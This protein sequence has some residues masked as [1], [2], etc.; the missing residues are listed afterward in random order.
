[1]TV[2]SFVLGTC[3]GSFVLC[4]TNRL[5]DGKPIGGRSHCDRCKH[6]LSWY[7]L[8][9]VVSWIAMRGRCRYCRGKIPVSFVG[10]EVLM[11]I[12]HAVIGYRYGVS[13]FTVLLWC[14]MAVVLS[15]SIEDINKYTIHDGYHVLLV[16]CRVVYAV[17]EKEKYFLLFV[18]EGLLVMAGIYVLSV[19]MQ[20]L[21]HKVCLGMGDVKL[22][23]C[24]GLYVGIEGSWLVC[25][26]ASF[27]ALVVAAV[28]KKNKLPFGPFLG[29]AFLVVLTA[30]G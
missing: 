19:I 20:Q 23:G 12:L 3:T 16:L 8:V 13:S 15:L 14:L 24:I 29:W 5:L 21:L 22:L 6:E 9:P 2:F 25:A 1:M 4:V 11:G 26:A 28:L 18:V 27:A 10:V 7:D 17:V 30:C